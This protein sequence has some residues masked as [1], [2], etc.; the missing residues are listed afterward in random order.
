M[1]PVLGLTTGRLD[2]REL[3]NALNALGVEASS[4]DAVNILRH[5]DSDRNGLMEI[6]EFANLVS[7]VVATLE[8]QCCV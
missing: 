1:L 2:Y 6:N 8:L 5:Y 7:P 3:R 4:Q